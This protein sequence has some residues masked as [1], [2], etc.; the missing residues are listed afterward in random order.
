MGP[1]AL[2]V[3]Q[4]YSRIGYLPREGWF[5]REIVRCTQ[6]RARQNQGGRHGGASVSELRLA[7]DGPGR[8]NRTACGRGIRGVLRIPGVQAYTP[9]LVNR[10]TSR[11][12]LTGLTRLTSSRLFQA[13]IS[14]RQVRLYGLSSKGSAQFLEILGCLYLFQRLLGILQP[15]WDAQTS[16]FIRVGA[17]L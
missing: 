4:Y 1:E 8:E 16:G 11:T 15:G 7:H 10:R 12:G 9:D 17:L 14:R 5:Y 2:I 6:I 3:N 13:L